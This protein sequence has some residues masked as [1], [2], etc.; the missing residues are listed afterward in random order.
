MPDGGRTVVEPDGSPAPRVAEFPY[1]TAS[2]GP[3]AA[4]VAQ[5]AP[6]PAAQVSPPSVIV[7]RPAAPKTGADAFWQRRHLGRLRPGLLR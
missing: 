1:R 7:V 2:A 6:A 3:P 4:Q 5:P